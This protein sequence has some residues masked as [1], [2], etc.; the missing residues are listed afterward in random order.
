MAP[1]P[2]YGELDPAAGKMARPF[3]DML[4]VICKPNAMCGSTLSYA[5]YCGFHNTNSLCGDKGCVF[6]MRLLTPPNSLSNVLN[7]RGTLAGVVPTALAK[8]ELVVNI[9]NDQVWNM[10]YALPQ[11]KWSHS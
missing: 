1:S 9:V 7:I 2:A 8:Q 5:E 3:N 11:A 6:V 10:E 4:S